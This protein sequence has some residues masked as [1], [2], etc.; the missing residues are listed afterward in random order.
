MTKPDGESDDE[1]REPTKAV[2]GEGP[3]AEICIH[4]RG[5]AGCKVERS[6]NTYNKIGAG[7]LRSFAGDETDAAFF[8]ESVYILVEH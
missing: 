6:K 3:R 4:V 7:Y 1:P 5:S 8:G 2:F